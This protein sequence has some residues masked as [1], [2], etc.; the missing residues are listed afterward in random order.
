MLLRRGQQLSAPLELLGQSS[1]EIFNLCI[2]GDCDLLIHCSVRI[3]AKDL[4]T[5]LAVQL[6]LPDMLQR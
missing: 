3:N 1:H 5:R 6:D 2:W 4:V